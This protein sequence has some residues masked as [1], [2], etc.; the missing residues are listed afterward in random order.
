MSIEK[1]I[2]IPKELT[3]SL[4]NKIRNIE[5]LS[6]IEKIITTVSA[7]SGEDAEEVKTWDFLSL[8]Q[9]YKLINDNIEETKSIFLPI[10]DFEGKQ[11]G[12]QPISKMSGG[13][14][15]DL[16][17]KM[18]KGVDGLEDIIS[19]LYRPIT[20]SRFNTLEWKLK[21]NVKYIMGKSEDLFKY[22]DIEEYDNEKCEWR[23]EVL[24]E[25]PLS[26][27]LGAYN[28]FLV[29]GWQLSKNMLTYSQHLS[30]EKKKEMMEELDQVSQSIMVGSTS[31][32]NWR[33]MVGF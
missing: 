15:I 1:E 4:W 31:Y 24:R 29:L 20:K 8:T 10:I 12:F 23:K 16:E 27:A 28:F 9:V 25:L 19:H 5:H 21:N 33:K 22:Y 7:V 6:D 3:I 2:Q 32:T 13:E 26:I 14:Y 18:K 11:Y 17:A 30:E